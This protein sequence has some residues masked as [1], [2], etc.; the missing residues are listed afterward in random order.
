MTDPKTTLDD[1]V[2][3]IVAWHTS[4]ETGTPVWIDWAN[5]N[6]GKL[7]D[8]GGFDDLIDTYMPRNTYADQWDTEGLYAQ[9]IERLNIDVPVQP[10]EERK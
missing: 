7:A 8:I 6:P 1:H 3:T 10:Q 5:E 2:R 4:S 9:V